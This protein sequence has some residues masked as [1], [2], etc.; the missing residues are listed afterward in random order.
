MGIYE[1]LGIS[2]DELGCVMLDVDTPQFKKTPAIAELEEQGDMESDSHI[3]LLFGLI[4]SNPTWRRYV[5]ECLKDWEKP[6]EAFLADFEIFGD[7]TEDVVVSTI[8][9]K[10]QFKQAHEMLEKLPHINTY[11]YE[12]HMTIGYFPKGLGEL[13]INELKKAGNY[14]AVVKTKGINYGYTMQKG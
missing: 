14:R 11:P 5:D 1:E 9:N 2:F 10:S 6:Q 12:P 8:L 3:T 4:G 7:G 13:Y